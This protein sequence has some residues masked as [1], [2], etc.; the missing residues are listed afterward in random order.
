[1][2]NAYVVDDPK[3]MLAR[4]AHRK[5]VEVIITYIMTREGGGINNISFNDFS[6]AIK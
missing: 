2:Q 4:Q 1:M 5:R 3:Q 6:V